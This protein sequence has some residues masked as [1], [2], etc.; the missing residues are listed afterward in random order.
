MTSIEHDHLPI[1]AKLAAGEPVLWSSR[2]SPFVSMWSK[3]WTALFALAWLALAGSGIKAAH[4]HAGTTQ[5]LSACAGFFIGLCILA[6]PF[7]EY[8][9][10]RKTMYV[11]T[12]K[13][14]I[15][16]EADRKR[17][18]SIQLSAIHHV[19][20]WVKWD[21]VSLRIPTALV[22]EGEDG[23]KVDYTDLHGLRDGDRAY[24]LLVR[25]VI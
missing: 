15:I 13:R 14:L 5:F 4:E 21:R 1:L 17:I 24:E 9:R 20:H 18:K 8:F 2:P 3:R 22:S 23:Q 6:D 25:P 7:L 10:A 11:I 16:A 12:D 19:E